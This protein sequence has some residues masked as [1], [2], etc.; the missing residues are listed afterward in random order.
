MEINSVRWLQ[1]FE[2][3]LRTILFYGMSHQWRAT[4]KG[5]LAGSFSGL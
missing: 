5:A 4:K 2:T 3:M 1:G